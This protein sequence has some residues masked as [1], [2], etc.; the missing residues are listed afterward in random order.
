MI[1]CPT[2]SLRASILAFLFCWLLPHATLAGLPGA[3]YPPV[4]PGGTAS[5]TVAGGA[6]CYADL[7][8]AR[9]W[10]SATKAVTMTGTAG[11]VLRFNPIAH[12]ATFEQAGPPS[13]INLLAGAEC[14][15]DIRGAHFTQTL[16]GAVGVSNGAIDRDR[17]DAGSVASPAVLT[18][19]PPFPTGTTLIPYTTPTTAVAVG[20]TA[21]VTN[22]T[23]L[24]AATVRAGVLRAK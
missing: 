19:T 16:I 2:H 24:G 5:F 20:A 23:L 14:D 4:N 9:I 10:S 8:G 13:A 1:T 12:G 6:I 3:S 15:F 7:S 18:I 17:Y 21:T 11:G 22:I